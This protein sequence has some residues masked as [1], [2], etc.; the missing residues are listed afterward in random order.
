MVIEDREFVNKVI[1]AKVVSTEL[2]VQGKMAF[3]DILF[4]T[5]SAD[6]KPSS[7]ATLQVIS[8]VISGEDTLNVIVVGHTDNQ[9]SLETNINLSRARA[10]A[11]RSKLVSTFGVPADR[12][13]SAG[14]AYLAP[15]T[16]NSTAEG[17]ALNR[18]V[19]IVVR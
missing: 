6:L 19:E 17:R 12:I 1:D 18:R 7:D 5:G 4:E 2:T 16:T 8:E 13:S 11:V 15:V 9:G 14:V 10:E 3:Y